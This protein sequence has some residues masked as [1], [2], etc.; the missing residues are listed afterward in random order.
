MYFSGRNL[1][2]MQGQQRSLCAKRFGVSEILHEQ[3]I[4]DVPILF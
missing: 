4:Y 1:L 3:A 2:I